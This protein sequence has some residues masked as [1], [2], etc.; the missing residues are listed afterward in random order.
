[1]NRIIG[2]NGIDKVIEYDGIMSSS[3]E[4]RDHTVEDIIWLLVFYGLSIRMF[5]S[6]TRIC[7]LNSSIWMISAYQTRFHK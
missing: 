2:S 7:F 6:Q 1:M 3:L 5:L 4:D